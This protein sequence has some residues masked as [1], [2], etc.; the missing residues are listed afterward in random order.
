VAAAGPT[1]ERILTA[2]L[3]LVP[4]I[5]DDADELIEVFGDQ[6]LY[7]FLASRPTTTE[8]LRTRWAALAAARLADTEGTPQR[9]WTVRRRGDG[10]AVGMLQAAFSEQGRTAEIAWAVGVPWQGHGIASEAARGLVGW[11]ERRGVATI[12]AHIHPGHRASATVATRAGLQPTG[13]YRDHEGIREQPWR[14]E[15]E[16]PPGHIQ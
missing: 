13:A 4:V 8:Q 11:L 14:R 5:A 7:A 1:D 16:G 10:R 2:R 15:V 3:E 12:T 9:N 6:R